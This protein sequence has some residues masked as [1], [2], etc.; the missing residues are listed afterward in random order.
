MEGR[1]RALILDSAPR[2]MVEYAM[3]QLGK[4]KKATTTCSQS[5][6]DEMIRRIVVSV[7]PQQ[8]VLFGSAARGEWGPNSDLDVLIVMPDGAHRR[9][10]AQHIYRDLIGFPIATDVIVATQH[11]LAQGFEDPSLVYH[12]ALK[13]G[14]ELYHAG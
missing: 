1:C 6:L 13:Q 3:K 4:Q 11:D 14:R 7:N 8:I 12:E 2:Y 9:K 10:T 5:V